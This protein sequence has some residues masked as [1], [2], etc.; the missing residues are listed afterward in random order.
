MTIIYQPRGRAREYSEYAA[1][2]YSGCGHGCIYCYAPSACRRKAEEFHRD[3]KPRK[4]ILEKLERNCRKIQGKD[5]PRVLFCFTTDPYQPIEMIHKITRQAI[6]T[7]HKH[8]L[9][10][11]ILTK[12]GL[13]AARDFDLLTP[14]DAYAAT[15]TL[16]D[17]E[18]SLKWEPKAALPYNRIDSLRA[19]HE[20]GIPTWASLEPVIDPEQSLEIIRQTHEFIDLYKVGKLNYRPE[21]KEVDWAKFAREVVEL[22]DSLGKRYYIKKDL[23]VFLKTA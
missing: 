15:L 19:A 18:Q 20:M 5:M 3:P 13:R 21:A 1:N 11:Q 2:L 7:L 22:L 14:K 6:Q 9:P 12:G 4:D 10:V 17:D 23:Q 8:G 16:L